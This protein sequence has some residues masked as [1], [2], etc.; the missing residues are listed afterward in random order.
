MHNEIVEELSGILETPPD[1]ERDEI[2]I[3][4]ERQRM[5]NRNMIL[6]SHEGNPSSFMKGNSKVYKSLLTV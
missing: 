4:S 5:L 2:F 3:G 1:F 6:K